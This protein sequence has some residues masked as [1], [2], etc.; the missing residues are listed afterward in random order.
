MVPSFWYHDA[1]WLQA[2]GVHHSRVFCAREKV[3]ARIPKMESRYVGNPRMLHVGKNNAIPCVLFVFLLLPSCV[4]S[5]EADQLHANSAHAQIFVK[6]NE[7]LQ[8]N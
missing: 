6:T 5:N 4:G 8:E 3:S 7:P 1:Y 2:F